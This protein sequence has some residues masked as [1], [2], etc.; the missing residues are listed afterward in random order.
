[1][2]IT[3]PRETLAYHL[4]RPLVVGRDMSAVPTA[5]TVA[6]LQDFRNADQNPSTVPEAE[7]LC[8]YALNH[9]MAAIRQR[10]AV[11]EPLGADLAFVEAYHRLVGPRAVRAFYYLFLICSR[12]SRHVH[13]S[14]TLNQLLVGK[15]GQAAADFNLKIKGASSLAAVNALLDTPPDLPL[16]TF[17]N[18]LRAVFYQGKFS[19]GY[20][21]P[22]WGMIADCLCRFVAGEISAEMMLDTVWTLNHNN[23]AI[24]NKQMFYANSTARLM[25]ILDVQRSGQVPAMVLHDQGI[26]SFVSAELKDWMLWLRQHHPEAV[27]PYVDW[28]VVEALGAKSSYFSDKQLQVAKHGPSPLAAAAEAEKAEQ[29]QQA[30]IDEAAAALKH[31]KNFFQVMPGLEVEKIHRAAA[32]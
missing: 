18:S 10:R 21:G 7:A 30:A 27:P 24:F 9:G 19:N 5:A 14:A 23:G 3:D 28:F 16:G 20:G 15:F 4:A 6:A 31:A 11:H 2:S 29:A 13:N 8:F 22:A 25:R 12:E 26:K 32:A 17:V 1:M